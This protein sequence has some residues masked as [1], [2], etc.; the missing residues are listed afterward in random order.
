LPALFRKVFADSAAPRTV[1]GRAWPCVDCEVLAK[2]QR[3]P[4]TTR[5]G[6][7]PM[8]ALLQLPNPRLVF[9]SGGVVA[10]DP[11]I[12]DYYLRLLPLS[13]RRMRG[14]DS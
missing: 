5:S 12:V 14:G 3:L 7:C 2:V 4:A 1:V 8:L 13:A 10:I 6:S 9:V 11:A